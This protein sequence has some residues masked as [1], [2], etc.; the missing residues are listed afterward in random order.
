MYEWINK[1]QT[2]RCILNKCSVATLITVAFTVRLTAHIFHFCGAQCSCSS[3]K[4]SQQ[5]V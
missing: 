5:H 3:V 1:Y 4:L 2:I